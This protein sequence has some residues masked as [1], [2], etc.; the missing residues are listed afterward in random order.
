MKILNFSSHYEDCGIAKYQENYNDEINALE[1]NSAE[2]FSFS[3]YQTREMNDHEFSNVIHELRKTI[4][5]YDIFHIQH[6]FGFF[7][8][9]QLQQLID[10][11]KAANV[12]VVVTYHTSPDL[13]IIHKPLT[14]LGPKSI[15]SFLRS[16]RHNKQLSNI[17]IRPLLSADLVI[18][19]NEYTI[20]QLRRYGVP[21]SIL[22]LIPHPTYSLTN[23]KPTTFIA[24][25][26][27]KKEGD[28]ILS[29]IGYLHRFKGIDKAIKALSYLPNNYKLAVLGGVKSDS[30]DQ[31][32]YDTL[33]DLV[34]KRDLKD[35]VYFTGVVLEDE[36]LNSYIRETDISLYPYNSVYYKGVASGALNLAIAN[37][38]PIVAYP[39]STFKETNSEINQLVLTQSDSYYELA[40]EVESIDIKEQAERV[41]QYAE[42]NSWKNM[43]TRLIDAYKTIL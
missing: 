42:A 22:T 9:A 24:E 21:A 8:G 20:G 25:S 16:Q 12:K 39:V 4:K 40:K 36:T 10:T 28:I 27:N 32:L 23:P 2:F 41:K 29:T 14:G 11:A 17:H 26:L 31:K 38:R 15:I 37:E 19:H 7:R 5:G 35:R 43:S 30:N 33:A 18:A 34:I 13:I 6:E 1:S 3:P